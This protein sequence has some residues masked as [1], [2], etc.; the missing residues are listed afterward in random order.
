MNK[1]ACSCL[2]YALLY[3]LSLACTLVLIRDFL[4]LV[5]TD[6]VNLTADQL[7]GEYSARFGA[8]ELLAR[9]RDFVCLAKAWK[10]LTEEVE[11]HGRAESAECLEALR[12]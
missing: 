5:E 11:R 4:S 8:P 6:A 2:L 12:M 7:Y 3:L 1:P 10:R 9:R